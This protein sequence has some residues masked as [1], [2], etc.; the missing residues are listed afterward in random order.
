MSTFPTAFWK[1]N[2]SVGVTTDVSLTPI[3]WTTNL[4]YGYYLEE[5]DVT[6]TRT[7]PFNDYVDEGG[8][9]FYPSYNPSTTADSTYPIPYFGWYLDGNSQYPLSRYHRSDP[10]I[11]EGNGKKID[12]F[13]EADYDTLYQLNW[14]TDP[15]YDVQYYNH[16]IQSGRAVGTFTLSSSATLQILVSGL[17]ERY[18]ENPLAY[19]RLQLYL[20]NNLIC[21]GYAPEDDNS[22]PWDMNHS[23]F[24][25][26]SNTRTPP[27]YAPNGNRN[28]LN[29]SIND[30]LEGEPAF[31]NVV[32]QYNRREYVREAA[33]FTGSESLNAGNHTI[34]IFYNTN[35]GFYNSGAFYG[36]TFSFS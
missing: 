34:E 21:K 12:L 8:T 7:F 3:N 9:D 1:K 31:T 16:F 14:E 36:A 2:P 32:D 19:D 30:G 17:G 24:F 20:N 18:T 23:K 26:A 11:V 10:W 5:G 29:T 25:N 27:S 4:Y 13:F 35:D 6:T 28:N 33:R 15:A 22:R